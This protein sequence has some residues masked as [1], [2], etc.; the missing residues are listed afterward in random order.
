MHS[1]SEGVSEHCIQFSVLLVLAA[2]IAA[3]TARDKI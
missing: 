3:S 1:L 2:Y